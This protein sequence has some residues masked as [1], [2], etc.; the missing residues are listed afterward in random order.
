[1]KTFK[2]W[3]ERS[4]I[5]REFFEIK[6]KTLEEAKNSAEAGDYEPLKTKHMYGEALDSWEDDSR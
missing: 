5:T 2:I 4:D 1:M 3:V 6:A